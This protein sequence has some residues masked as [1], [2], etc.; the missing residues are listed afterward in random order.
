MRNASETESYK[1]GDISRGVAG[2]VRSLTSNPSAAASSAAE[3]T[4]ENRVKLSGAG[5][6]GIGMVAGMALLGPVG[7]V[8][9]SIIGSKAARAAVTGALGDPKAQQ[10]QT[11]T[12]S[13]TEARGFSENVAD[14][15]DTAFEASVSSQ[16]SANA[17]PSQRRHPNLQAEHIR[18]L[19]GR[20]AENKRETQVPT[21]EQINRASVME[22][23]R[24][25]QQQTPYSV[26]S[27]IG[28]P[29]RTSYHTS[30]HTQSHP[31]YAGHARDDPTPQHQQSHQQ[32]HNPR[33][34][35]HNHQPQEGAHYRQNFDQS[36]MQHNHQQYHQRAPSQQQQRH[37]LI[38][39]VIARGK[40]Q[41]GQDPNS[42]YKFGD[43]TR[44]LF[45]R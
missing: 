14:R 20:L 18:S 15:R 41:R 10:D 5:G 7:L 40:Q 42:S 16:A 29:N 45:G 8:A 23:P 12:K 31:S 21:I 33:L 43:F 27:S 17:A 4:T 34:Q 36:S 30:Q 6:A 39:G 11:T 26:Y 38:S 9:G 24:P 19:D 28:D 35:Q 13:P 25:G 3:Y 2:S 32:F 37:G 1:F 44:G 22:Y